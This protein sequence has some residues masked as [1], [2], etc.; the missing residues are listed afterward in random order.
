MCKVDCGILDVLFAVV[1]FCLVGG[2]T[3]VACVGFHQ[4]TALPRHLRKSFWYEGRK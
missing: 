2:V 4:L 1:Y 3:V